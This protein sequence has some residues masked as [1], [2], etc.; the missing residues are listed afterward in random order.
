MNSSEKS[1]YIKNIERM[2]LAKKSVLCNCEKNNSKVVAEVMTK[3]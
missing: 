2:S 3:A 1:K